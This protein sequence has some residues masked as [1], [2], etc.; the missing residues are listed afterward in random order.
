MSPQSIRSSL[1][2]SKP[3]MRSAMSHVTAGSGN[4]SG[5]WGWQHIIA[6][7]LGMTKTRHDHHGCSHHVVPSAIRLASPN[8]NVSS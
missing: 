6:A 4:V 7:A 3:G 5:C 8:F 1:I 2:G